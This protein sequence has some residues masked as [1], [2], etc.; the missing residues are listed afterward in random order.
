MN[1]ESV[2]SKQRAMNYSKMRDYEKYHSMLN[3]SFEVLDSVS[4]QCTNPKGKTKGGVNYYFNRIFLID[5]KGTKKFII[6]DS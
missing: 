6:D 4:N 1:N 2:N 3:K 5:C